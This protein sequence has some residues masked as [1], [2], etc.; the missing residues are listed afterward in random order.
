M[1][2]QHQAV[3]QSGAGQPLANRSLPREALLAKARAYRESQINREAPAAEQLSMNMD[4]LTS[5]SRLTPEPMRSPFATET[6][7]VPSYLR[8]KRGLNTENPDGLE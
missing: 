5:P 4:E 7:E 2:Q 6:L 1:Q 8:R 3:G